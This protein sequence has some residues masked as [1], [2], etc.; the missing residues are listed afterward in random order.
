MRKTLADSYISGVGAACMDNLLLCKFLAAKECNNYFSSS[1]EQL[2]YSTFAYIQVYVPTSCIIYSLM[3]TYII[4]IYLIRMIIY[5]I[6]FYWLYGVD[7]PKD[8]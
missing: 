3:V 7:A 2:I 1:Y 6:L 5:F 4:S 8:W